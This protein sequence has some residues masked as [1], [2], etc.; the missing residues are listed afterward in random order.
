MYEK[1]LGLASWIQVAGSGV[2]DA[3]RMARDI[4]HVCE[5]GTATQ[6]YVG[7]VHGEAQ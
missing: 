2:T 1:K 7:M 3:D 4:L 5:K 6:W